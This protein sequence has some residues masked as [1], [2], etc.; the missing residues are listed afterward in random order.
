MD[1]PGSSPRPDQSLDPTSSLIRVLVLPYTNNDPTVLGQSE[2]GVSISPYIRFELRG[3]PFTVRFRS[4]RVPRAAVPEAAVDVDRHSGSWED[5]IGT[6]ATALQGRDIYP[7]TQPP[8]PNR[9]AHVEF[10]FRVAPQL[11]FHPST[12]RDR[13]RLRSSY[14]RSHLRRRT[15]RR[16]PV[17]RVLRRHRENLP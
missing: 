11:S 3:P 4:R 5:Q 12:A 16:L 10:R 14:G 17:Q 13:R 8:P 6:P 15:T 2:I 9:L 1:S 7:I